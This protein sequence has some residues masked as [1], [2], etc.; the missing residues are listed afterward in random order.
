MKNLWKSGVFSVMMTL[1][2]SLPV[3][4]GHVSAV[5][6]QGLGLNERRI[7]SNYQKTVYP[8]LLKEVQK[9]AGFDVAVEPMWESFFKQDF[10]ENFG[11]DWYLKDVFFKPLIKALQSVTRDDEGKTALKEKLHKIVM[12]YDAETAPVSNYKNGVSFA[13]GVLTLNFAP[14]VNAADIDNRASAIEEILSQG[15]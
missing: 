11:D 13:D 1:G 10:A 12:K 5:Q 2:L 14:G 6:A 8:E 3:A 15:L 4:V 9:A 7:V